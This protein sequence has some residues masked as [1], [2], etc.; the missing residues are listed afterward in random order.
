VRNKKK[1]TWRRKDNIGDK[2]LITSISEKNSS[3]QKMR[4]DVDDDVQEIDSHPELRQN[5]K[6]QTVTVCNRN[7]INTTPGLW[8]GIGI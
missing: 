5:S 4:M 8:P 3:N 2:F 7:Y 6:H 1:I